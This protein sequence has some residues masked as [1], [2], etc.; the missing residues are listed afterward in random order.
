MYVP[1]PSLDPPEDSRR[2]VAT[3]EVCGEPIREYDDL[4]RIP[5]FGC[6]CERCIDEAREVEVTID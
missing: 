5:D 3:C 2:V 6:V 4:W 1:E